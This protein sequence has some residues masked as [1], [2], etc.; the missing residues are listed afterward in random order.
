M[1]YKSKT[2]KKGNK[3]LISIKKTKKYFVRFPLDQKIKED[4]IIEY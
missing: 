2:G 3:K 4:Q 1:I